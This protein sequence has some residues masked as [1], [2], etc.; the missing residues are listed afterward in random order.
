[1][2]I[3]WYGVPGRTGGK[4]HFVEKNKPICN[5]FLPK[6]SEFQWCITDIGLNTQYHS[7]ECK[8]S[9]YKKQ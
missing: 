3:G 4:T 2:N 6:D 1:M 7:V 5:T 9:L 8:K